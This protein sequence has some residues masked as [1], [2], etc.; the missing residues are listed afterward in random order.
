MRT[1]AKRTCVSEHRRDDLDA[2]DGASSPSSHAQST[3]A[4]RQ[5]LVT[6]RPATSTAVISSCQE[7]AGCSRSALTANSGRQTSA[8]SGGTA[9]GSPFLVGRT[10]SGGWGESINN[11]WQRRSRH[12]RIHPFS[13][14][15]DR[16]AHA[17]DANCNGVHAKS[18]CPCVP[19]RPV[20]PH[21]TM[22]PCRTSHPCDAASHV[23]PDW[24][25]RRAAPHVTAP[26][27]PSSLIPT[28]LDSS[29]SSELELK[30]R[31]TGPDFSG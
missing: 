28:M 8:V 2:C 24:T 30:A 27:L 19:G 15:S 9:W 21:D 25:T 14:I 12:P 18:R 4:A 23:T 7:G 6:P 31:L 17:C 10:G 5:D 11:D 3:T 20:Q 13:R 16:W 22:A 26:T 1:D 29:T